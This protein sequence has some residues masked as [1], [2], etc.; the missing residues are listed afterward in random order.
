MKLL[1]LFVAVTCIILTL[2]L[3][4]C[5]TEGKS[6]YEIA[7]DNGFDGTVEE[8]LESLK[9]DT[10][11]TGAKGEKGDTGAKGEKGDTGAKGDDGEV[12]TITG[13]N[14][15]G[16]THGTDTYTVILSD[17]STK[18]FV[19][20]YAGKA[21]TIT[22]ISKPE[23]T[24]KAI[25][26]TV[27]F[28][29]G[30][31]KTVS[32]EITETEAAPSIK[33][34]KLTLSIPSKD[35][36]EIEFSNQTSHR[37]EVECSAD[38]SVPYIGANGNWWIGTTDTGISN[39]ASTTTTGTAG[40]LFRATIKD[41]IT[42]YEVYGYT[43]S[44][45]DIVIPNDFF[46]YPVLSITDGALPTKIT[47]LTLSENTRQIP[48]FEDYTS[49]TCVDFNGAPISTLP[50]SVFRDCSSLKEIKNYENIEIISSYAFYNTKIS[51]FDFTNVTEI[52]TYAFY[53]SSLGD[54]DLI[55]DPSIFYIYI[56]SN[57]EKIGK[58]AFDDEFAIYYAGA[59]CEYSSEL[60]YKSVRF[61]DGYYYTDNG[62][63]VTIINYYGTSTDIVIPSTIGNKSVQRIADYAF[64]YNG[65]IERVEI[66]SSVSVIG[67]STFAYCKNLHSLF[68][69]SSVITI[70]YF[71]DFCVSQSSG[72]EATT[73]FFKATQFDYT[74]GITS[75]SQLGL[76]KYMVGVSPSD[77]IDDDVCVYYKK[78]TLIGAE[79]E[80]VSIKN[81][82]GTVNIPSSVGGVSVKRINSYAIY[83]STLTT[84]VDIPLTVEKISTK[85]FYNSDN[86][87]I[88][89]IPS[90]VEIINYQGL[91]DLPYCTAYIA[92]Q[93]KPTDWDSSWYY[94]LDGTVYGS[95]AEI[96]STGSYLYTIES[97]KVYLTKYLLPINTNTPIIIPEKVDGN[98]V[99]GIKTE[100][101]KSSA[102]SSSTNRFIFVIPDGIKYMERKA[103][104]F[105]SYNYAYTDLYFEHK[106]NV[107]FP[108]T[109]HS[110]WFYSYYG[111]SYNNSY[112]NRYYANDWTYVDGVPTKKA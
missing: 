5:S 10:G 78:A 20:N 67:E 60:L 38:G 84:V 32:L 14:M 89:N 31:E 12:V 71:D 39:S 4:A 81:V 99:Y 17:G 24:S 52:G 49:L 59:E 56:P 108:S 90:S 8:W 69:P 1:K 85:A 16:N 11:A 45:T 15:V 13:V 57:V 91:Y 98:A 35:I 105:P 63:Y 66:P 109:W 64:L 112:N 53:S 23:I 72:F 61:S 44:A 70:G 96:D 19:L 54:Y 82:A 22:G 50:N 106:S 103:I 34:I 42:G 101:F 29:N 48:D 73:V 33:G 30:T 111:G 6:A 25:N 94:N 104:Y 40:L 80:V 41:S 2:A 46:G 97:G 75:P 62:T 100:C 87:Q 47:S 28:S 86:L 107:N 110:E 83:G 21:P 68:I 88:I 55:K 18:S 93:Q 102:S 37:F 74:G 92:H 9:G 27:S 58:Y 51:K 77:I 26:Y 43:G 36:Y 79:Y 3:T 76:T 95:Q 7:K 65:R